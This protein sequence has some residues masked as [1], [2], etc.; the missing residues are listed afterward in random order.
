MA[1]YSQSEDV[2]VSAKTAIDLQKGDKIEF[3]CDLYT[4]DGTYQETYLMGTPIIINESAAELVI[5]DTPINQNGSVV[6]Y[7][8]TDIYGAEHWTQALFR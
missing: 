6:T 4:Y 2:N 5:N 7:V 3:V 1:D 8:F